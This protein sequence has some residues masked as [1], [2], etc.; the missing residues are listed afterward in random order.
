MSH[1]TD[2]DIEALNKLSSIMDRAFT[3]PGT[4]IHIGVDSILG[5]I[6]GIGDTLSAAVSGYIYTFAKKV[7]VP[8]Y[9][10]LRMIWNIFIDWFIGLIPL[11][12]DIFD[13]GFKANTRNVAIINDH[14]KKQKDKDIIDGDYTKIS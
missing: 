10:R 6:P 7:G 13:I 12:G 9:K 14:Y 11:I 2:K 8:W 4:N 1:I 5:L 3:I